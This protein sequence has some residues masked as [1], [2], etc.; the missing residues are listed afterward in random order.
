MQ[1]IFD[2]VIQIFNISIGKFY[3]DDYDFMDKVGNFLIL[4]KLNSNHTTIII[5]ING[6]KIRFLEAIDD[7]LREFNPG[8]LYEEKKTYFFEILNPE[9]V[10]K[11]ALFGEVKLLVE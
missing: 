6:R 9:S 8:H 5:N 4:T 1:I 10:S 3:I 11:I 2:K 7:I